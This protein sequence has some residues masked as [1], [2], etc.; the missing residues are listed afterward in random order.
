MAN[1]SKIVINA[2]TGNT[3]TV[4]LSD[5]EEAIRKDKL[6]QYEDDQPDRDWI[7]LRRKRTSKL[8][9]T[10][11]TQMPDAPADGK[12]AWATYRQALRD[13]PAIVDIL[14]WPDITW[15][16]KPED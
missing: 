9:A 2:S 15:P 16:T 13:L 8:K 1:P 10:D 12:T 14:Q 5:E 7:T 4:V 3:Q 11:W 6:K